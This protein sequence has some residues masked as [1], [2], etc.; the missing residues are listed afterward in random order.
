MEVLQVVL[1]SPEV[2]GIYI[3]VVDPHRCTWPAVSNEVVLTIGLLHIHVGHVGGRSRIS[4]LLETISVNW[5]RGVVCDVAILDEDHLAALLVHLIVEGGN[6]ALRPRGLVENEVL[7]IFGVL[8]VTP[9]HVDW[10][11]VLSEVL[12]AFDQ[13][14]SCVVFPLAVVEPE[15]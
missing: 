1:A 4:L 8:D 13:H 15:C 6:L 7:L 14:F 11:P 12:V 9:E 10:E 3:E 2:L 5:E